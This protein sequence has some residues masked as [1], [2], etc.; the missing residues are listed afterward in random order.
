MLLFHNKLPITV[1]G[2]GNGGTWSTNGGQ[3]LK[4]QVQY[5]QQLR[6]SGGGGGEMTHYG[7]HNQVQTASRISRMNGAGG[8]GWWFT[9]HLDLVILYLIHSSR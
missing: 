2:G 1:G 3:V 9:K 4:V 7:S 6:G 8:G 5:F